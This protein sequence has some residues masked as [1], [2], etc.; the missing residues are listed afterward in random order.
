[1]GCHNLSLK[2]RE[3]YIFS[4]ASL[5]KLCLHVFIYVAALKWK[6]QMIKI[7]NLRKKNFVNSFSSP[8]K[9]RWT[10]MLRFGSLS[11][12][13]FWYIFTIFAL[14]KSIWSH[15][16]NIMKGLCISQVAEKCGFLK[17]NYYHLLRVKKKSNMS[18][19]VTILEVCHIF[20]LTCKEFS[21]HTLDLAIL[22]LWISLSPSKF[23]N[24]EF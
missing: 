11:F 23:V 15:F 8:E 14:W 12:D 16:S 20:A 13:V 5:N 2:T 19:C 21:K 17:G 6:Q 9:S 4:V 10:W 7:T 22:F 24:I 3:F 18:F 1:M